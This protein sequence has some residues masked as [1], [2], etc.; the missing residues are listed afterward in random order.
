MRS[1]CTELDTYVS[2]KKDHGHNFL[3]PKQICGYR[4]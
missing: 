3:S 2:L 1:E 4:K